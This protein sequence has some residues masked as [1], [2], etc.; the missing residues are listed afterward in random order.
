LL[1]RYYAR[2][3]SFNKTEG[4]TVKDIM[5]SEVITVT[6]DKTILEA[7]RTMRDNKIGCLPVVKDNELI[8]IIT[9][10]DFLR[11]STPFFIVSQYFI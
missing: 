4:V 3:H 9:E 11:I 1:L 8:G 5:V 2:Q 10:M 6:P 7:L